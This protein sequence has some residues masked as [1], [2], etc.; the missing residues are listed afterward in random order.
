MLI[1]NQDTQNIVVTTFTEN[2]TQTGTVYYLWECTNDDTNESVYFIGTDISTNE[3]RYNQFVIELTT[4][5]EDLL[6]SIVT[7]APNGTWK[8]KAY[9]QSSSTNLDPAI[10]GEVVEYG[11]IQ[12]IGDVLPTR[13]SYND[14][15]NTNTYYEG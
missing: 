7:M 3:F 13:D 11:R 12:V 9:Q 5:T 1:L 8:Y 15:T 4:G 10:S 14:Q 6:D 2:T